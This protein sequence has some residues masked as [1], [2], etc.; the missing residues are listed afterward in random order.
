MFCP[1]TCFAMYSTLYI[2]KK[3]AQFS[4][5]GLL[6]LNLSYYVLGRWSPQQQWG[7]RRGGADWGGGGG[8]GVLPPSLTNV[9]VM[10][11]ICLLLLEKSQILPKAMNSRIL[12]HYPQSP[13][14]SLFLDVSLYTCHYAGGRGGGG[15]RSGADP[16]C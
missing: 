1:C 15:A 3:L 6:V 7:G 12:S 11:Y 9:C 8:C 5:K 4:F 14:Q 10:C 2:L 13:K 16:G